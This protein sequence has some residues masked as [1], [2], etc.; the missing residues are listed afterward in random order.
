MGDGSGGSCGDSCL[1]GH[2]KVR[3]LQLHV[4]LCVLEKA[5]G[6]VLAVLERI[7]NLRKPA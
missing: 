4:D 5:L 1:V 7:L 2:A 6:F 3:I